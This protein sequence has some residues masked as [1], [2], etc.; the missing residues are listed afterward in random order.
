M[1]GRNRTGPNGQGAMTGRGLGGCTNRYNQT[2]NIYVYKSED[3]IHS[4]TEPLKKATQKLNALQS[5]ELKK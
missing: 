1:P 3:E 4:L 2:K 5:N